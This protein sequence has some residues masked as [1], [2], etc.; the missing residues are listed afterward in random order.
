M[1]N[2]YFCDLHIHIGRAGDGSPVKITASDKLDF[3]SI[4]RESL[5]NKGLDLV[6][7]I[8]CASPAVI[9]DI[10]KLLD[11]GEMK[12]LEKGGICY[13]EQLVIIP[14]AEVESK[15]YNGGQAHYIAFFPFINNLK[16]FSLIMDQYITNIGLSS[17]NTGLTG[18]EILKIVEQ[19]GGI[20]IPA[21]VFT[22]HKS[23]Y[24]RCFK[25]YKEVFSKEEWDKIPAIELG[26]SADSYLAAHLT[27]LNQ[28]TFL[29][30][31][32]AHSAGK[33]AREYNLI[34]M[35]ELNY[36]EFKKALFS[37]EKRKVIKNFG[38]DPR[39]GK[40]HRSYCN[41]CE[42]SFPLDKVVLKCPVCNNEKNIITG[43]KDRIYY[44]AD[45]FEI[46]RKII[47]Y[48]HQI[49][50]ADIP[51]I[52]PK[53]LK[54]LLSTFDTEMELIHNTELKELKKIVSSRIAKNIEKARKGKADIKSG[55]GGN[56]GKVMG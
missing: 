25:S 38:L 16:E 28:K 54:K 20:L 32:D 30:N 33:I 11:S 53:T 24:G 43:V 21:H 12:E 23:F 31:S 50:L 4:A 13:Q 15:E 10:E 42:K 51:G 5:N 17:Q 52:G 18:K 56:Y 9:D 49:P 1:L 47:N 46:D 27:E 8:D 26:L 45:N 14:G 39:L 41:Q 44:I 6:G 40:Y 3:A 48:I 37:E 2:E 36:E 35:K 29:S 34:R 7:I 55:G 22:P 19:A